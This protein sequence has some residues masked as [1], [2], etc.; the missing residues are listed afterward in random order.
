M[1]ILKISFIF[2][3][4]LFNT[5]LIN[6]DDNLTLFRTLYYK[7]NSLTERQEI[8]EQMDKVI[9]DEFKNFI[10]EIVVDQSNYNYNILQTKDYENWVLTTAKI[11]TKLKIA[12]A[13]PFLEKIYNKC[14]TSITKGQL[15][16]TIAQTGDRN[17]VKWFNNLLYDINN[18]HRANKFIKQEEIVQGIV[19]GLGLFADESSFEI[20]LY[21]AMPYFSDNTQALAKESLEKITDNPAKLCT[22]IIINNPDYETKLDAL[23]YALESNSPEEDKIE[24]C[25]ST[26]KKMNGVIIENKFKE[27]L[28]A[29]LNKSV[30]YLGEKR[31]KEKEVVDMIEEKWNNENEF[32]SILTNIEALE[33][34][35]TEDAANVLIRKL[36]YWNQRKKEGSKDGYLVD[37]GPKAIIALIKALGII[38]YNGSLEVLYDTIW[39]DGYGEPIKKEALNSIDLIMNKIKK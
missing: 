8:L 39:T 22:N 4:I 15:L 25:K 1:K 24:M 19:I 2:I 17:Y 37:Q 28:K 23:I 6:S 26:L 32:Y 16:V 29:L 13:A 10:M 31:V 21:D 27:K 12:E 5:I 18:L 35:A 14:K 30:Y 34:I 33:K 9:T 38:K 20:L 11:V 7:A 36:T 3:F